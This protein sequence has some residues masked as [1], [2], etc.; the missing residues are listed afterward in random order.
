MAKKDDKHEEGD[1]GTKAESADVDV[2][3]IRPIDLEQHAERPIRQEPGSREPEEVPDTS[4]AGFDRR[5][6]KSRAKR[7]RRVRRV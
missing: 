1:R 5:A 6:G 7:R 4:P 2:G 3:P